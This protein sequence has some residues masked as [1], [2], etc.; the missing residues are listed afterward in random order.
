MKILESFLLYKG[1]SVSLWLIS[2]KE[3]VLTLNSLSPYDLIMVAQWACLHMWV[4]QSLYHT[5][6][7]PAYVLVSSAT[8]VVCMPMVHSRHVLLVCADMLKGICEFLSSVWDMPLFVYFSV[9][10]L[11]HEEAIRLRLAL[12]F[13]AMAQEAR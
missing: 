9:F 5:A 1:L 2:S 10:L 8:K 11:L 6:P 12:W 3:N 13:V 4:C 7:G